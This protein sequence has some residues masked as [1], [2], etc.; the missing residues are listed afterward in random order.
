MNGHPKASCMKGRYISAIPTTHSCM[1]RAASS[2]LPW[3][4]GVLLVEV[5]EEGSASCYSNEIRSRLSFC[6]LPRTPR[7]N[8]WFKPRQEV[9]PQPFERVQISASFSAS[10]PC[11]FKKLSGVGTYT[12]LP[13]I[14][15]GPNVKG[16]RSRPF[17]ICQPLG[18][19]A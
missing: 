10:T 2:T 16:P 19:A 17:V 6:I 15:P 3:G 5:W 1:T 11:R 9:S 4:K 7:S 12:P 18:T 8:V 14:T 13:T